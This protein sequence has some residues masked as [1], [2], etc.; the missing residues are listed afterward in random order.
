MSCGLVVASCAVT[1]GIFNKVPVERLEY[2]GCE[3][4]LNPYGRPL[5]PAEIVEHAKDAD[6]IILG[7]DRLDSATIGKLPNLKLVV[8]HGAG[9]DNIDFSELGKRDITVANTPGANK[10]ETADL[11]FALILDLARM[12]TQSINQLKGGVWNKIPGRSLYGKTIGIIGVGAIGMA[13]AS[14]AMGFGMDIL[15][16]DIVQR[17]EAA[18]FG[19]LYTSLNELLSASD[20]VTIHAPLTSATKNLIGARELKRMK[21]GAL[22]INTARAGVVREAA[23]EKALMSG[24]L[25]GYAVDVYAKEPP[26]P[27]SYMSLPNVLTTPHIGSSTMEANLRMG[28]M[29]V[30]NIL[31]FMNGAVLP[32]K[33]TVVDRLRFS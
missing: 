22:L 2:A 3:V 32:N 30:D 4:R 23:L 8:R 14:R 33:V 12:V 7:N 26:D 25:G 21:P 9:L 18:R 13:V 5:T 17:D 24:H 19:L 11:T 1:F 10:E 20:V 31:A 16:N 28:D 27:T 15:G 6:V 29:A